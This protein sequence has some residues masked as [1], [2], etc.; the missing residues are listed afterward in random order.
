MFGLQVIVIP[1]DELPEDAE[2]VVNILTKESAPLH[3]WVTLALEYYRQ[4][5]EA[6]FVTIMEASRT[7]ANL[8]YNKVRRIRDSSTN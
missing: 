8:N 2:D 7:D 5:H 4:G 3:Y 6:E 1:F